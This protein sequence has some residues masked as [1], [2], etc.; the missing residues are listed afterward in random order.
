MQRAHI[1]FL[2]VLVQSLNEVFEELSD[3]QLRTSK[4]L[5]QMTAGQTIRCVISQG[6]QVAQRHIFAPMI[7][8]HP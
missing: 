5:N 4:F 8:L 3:S 1:F 6:R 7:E 2:L